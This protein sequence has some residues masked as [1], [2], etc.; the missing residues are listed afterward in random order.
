MRYVAQAIRLFCS[1]VESSAMVE[2]RTLWNWE[3]VRTALQHSPELLGELT[4]LPDQQRS[5]VLRYC[6]AF[7]PLDSLGDIWEFPTPDDAASFIKAME[8]SGLSSEPYTA[9][10]VH[11]HGGGSP[12]MVTDEAKIRG[13]WRYKGPKIHD[14]VDYVDASLPWDLYCEGID[15][16]VIREALLEQFN[17]SRRILSESNIKLD[18]RLTAFEGRLKSWIHPRSP[19]PGV[20]HYVVEGLRVGG[21]LTDTMLDQLIEQ[22]PPA[23]APPVVGDRGGVADTQPDDAPGAAAASQ[24]APAQAPEKPTEERPTEEQGAPSGDVTLADGTVVPEEVLKTAFVKFLDNVKTQLEQGTQ[25]GTPEPRGQEAEAQPKQQP[26]APQ[27]QEQQPPQPAQPPQPPQGAPQ[28]QQ[29]AKPDES[30]VE[31]RKAEYQCLECGKLF[32]STKEAEAA[33]RR[34]CPKCGGYD[35]DLYVGESA[36]H[37]VRSPSAD[38]LLELEQR[39][40]GLFD[41]YILK[42]IFLAGGGGSGKGFISSLMFGTM[43]DQATTAMGLKSVN[44]DD[45]FTALSRGVG[46][47]PTFDLKTDLGT[48]VADV[49]RVRAKQLLKKREKGWVG[50]RLGLIIDGTAKKIN[51]VLDAKKELEAAGYD[52]YMVFVNTSLEVAI[53]RNAARA[54]RVPEDLI[55]SAHVEVQAGMAAFKQVWGKRMIVIDNSQVAS[56][57]DIARK[58]VPSFHRAAMKFLGE[59]LRNPI[60]RDWIE[61]EAKGLPDSMKRKIHGKV[62]SHDETVPE[63]GL[64]E[65]IVQIGGEVYADTQ[66]LNQGKNLLPGFTVEHMG[67]GEFAFVGPGDARIEVDRM[68]GKPFPGQSGRSHKLYDNRNGKLVQQLFAAAQRAGLAESVATVMSIPVVLTKGLPLR[69]NSL[70]E[71]TMANIVGVRGSRLMLEAVGR[72]VTCAPKYALVLADGYD[73]DAALVDLAEGEDAYQVAT[74]RLNSHLDGA[75]LQVE[76]I[77]A[78]LKAVAGTAVQGAAE[79]MGQKAGEKIAGKMGGK[80]KPKPKNEAFW[81]KNDFVRQA[82]IGKRWGKVL[83]VGMSKV[84][85]PVTVYFENRK[86]YGGVGGGQAMSSQD[87]GRLYDGLTSRFGSVE[88]MHLESLDEQAGTDAEAPKRTAPATDGKASSTSGESINPGNRSG[89]GAA[90]DAGVHAISTLKPDKRGKGVKTTEG[91]Q[92]QSVEDVILGLERAW[93]SLEEQLDT[94]Q[95]AEQEATSQGFADAAD[96]LKE[97]RTAAFAL[98]TDDLV[99]LNSLLLAV[100]NKGAAGKVEKIRTALQGLSDMVKKAADELEKAHV[101]AGVGDAGMKQQPTEPNGGPVPAE[102]PPEAPVEAPPAEVVV[103][104]EAAP[105]VPTPPQ[106]SL[107]DAP[108][109]VLSEQ[110]PVGLSKAKWTNKVRGPFAYGQVVWAAKPVGGDPEVWVSEDPHTRKGVYALESSLEFLEHDVRDTV[111]EVAVRRVLDSHIPQRIGEGVDYRDVSLLIQGECADLGLSHEMLSEVHRVAGHGSHLGSFTV[112]FSTHDQ[113]LLAATND[114]IV[115][116][117]ADSTLDGG[118]AVVP[119]AVL[120]EAAKVLR[121]SSD[122]DQWRLADALD[123]VVSQQN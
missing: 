17:K 49:A 28:G 10:V 34:G 110:S 3:S 7:E 89:S 72:R 104:P 9:T 75:H 40:E 69:R 101:T 98:S 63:A 64:I 114:H 90:K 99:R 93:E 6:E 82:E 106:E 65:G 80:K 62:F 24:T 97:L 108:E 37:V 95:E 48:S 25:G 94:G 15:I 53:A 117:L 30:L 14:S 91:V 5:R 76:A 79:K 74:R 19:I 11:F 46:G 71:G 57:Q 102:A 70:S 8:S 58:L 107:E 87:L 88:Q 21:W 68:R 44:S 23:A 122:P 38:E 18:E 33:T 115:M 56:E 32:Y 54:R 83:R 39:D 45:I 42:A 78:A 113:G 29:Q 92:V 35:I 41:P 27:G 118:I 61:A 16:K 120:V 111:M 51:K 55:R 103:A 119:G 31:K 1:L 96:R 67:F 109:K 85:A 121:G 116:R 100:G 52:T 66:F 59:P 73:T 86:W 12:E 81:G 77:G 50:G 105:A 84:A 4:A 26:P 112:S 47:G 20:P 123:A 36:E 2:P 22:D 43:K 60:G 13:G